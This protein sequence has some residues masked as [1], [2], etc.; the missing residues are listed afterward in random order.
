MFGK[1]LFFILWTWL[2]IAVYSGWQCSKIGIDVSIDKLPS[3]ELQG[4]YYIELTN[5]T[6]HFHFI[7]LLLL[8]II[9]ANTIWMHLNIWMRNFKQLSIILLLLLKIQTF[10][11]AKTENVTCTRWNWSEI[12]KS[13]YV[14]AKF[15]LSLSLFL[16][17]HR[18]L[19]STSAMQLWMRISAWNWKWH[20]GKC[21]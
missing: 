18:I 21:T 9:N 4:F 17:A 20:C 3:F 19:R 1:R 8:V 12:I 2:S 6:V 5:E 16:C 7:N 13:E 11:F 10:S 15:S 14:V